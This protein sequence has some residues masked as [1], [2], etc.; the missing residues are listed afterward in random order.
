MQTDILASSDVLTL[1]FDL[2]QQ[3]GENPP[4]IVKFLLIFLFMVITLQR[5]TQRNTN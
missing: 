3:I 4:F 1:C 2:C 5:K